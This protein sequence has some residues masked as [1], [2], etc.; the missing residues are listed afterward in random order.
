[1][2]EA[3]DA[4]DGSK[5]GF[6]F[7]PQKCEFDP[8]T[9]KIPAATA[10]AIRAVM[11]GPRTRAG[12]QVYPGYFWDT[13]IATTQGLPGIL[14]GPFI[15]EGRPVGDTMDVDAAAAEAMDARAMVG[16]SSAWNAGGDGRPLLQTAGLGADTSVRAHHAPTDSVREVGLTRWTDGDDDSLALFAGWIVRWPQIET[17]LCPLGTAAGPHPTHPAC[18]FPARAPPRVG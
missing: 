6:V 5:D 15:P 16:D 1:M 14:A 4:L 3:C 7:A 2:L 11:Q 8:G 13:G 10:K 12:R 18:A 17:S 9:L